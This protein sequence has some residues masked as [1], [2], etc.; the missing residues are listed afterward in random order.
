MHATMVGYETI[1]TEVHESSAGRERKRQRSKAACLRCTIRKISCCNTRPCARCVSSTRV[2][3]DT[4]I[5][6]EVSIS[7]ICSKLKSIQQHIRGA[8]SVGNE[9][10]PVLKEFLHTDIIC[11]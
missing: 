6:A 1:K 2:C 10:S 5:G 9:T 7:K 11:R 3:E 4:S 8:D